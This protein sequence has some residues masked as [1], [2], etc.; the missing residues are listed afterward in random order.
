MVL[1]PFVAHSGWR[2]RLQDPRLQLQQEDNQC[3]SSPGTNKCAVHTHW[4][5]HI[6]CS[7]LWKRVKTN[8]SDDPRSKLTKRSPFPR[9]EPINK[10]NRPTNGSRR[11][12]THPLNHPTNS[13]ANHCEPTNQPIRNNAGVQTQWGY[14]HELGTPTN[15]VVNT[16]CI[17]VWG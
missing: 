1:L 16:G 3:N 13:K 9:Q 6:Q 7:T 8:G 10:T 11:P 4:G 15:C 17:L 12:V 14:L 5:H 2:S